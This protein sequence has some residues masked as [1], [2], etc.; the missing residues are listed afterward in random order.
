MTKITIL[1]ARG[2]GDG[3]LFHILSHNLAK[4]GHT[5]TTVHPTLAGLGPWLTQSFSDLNSFDILLLQHDNSLRSFALSQLPNVFCFYGAHVLDKHGPLKSGDFV[6][7]RSRTMVENIESALQQWFGITS[8]DPGLTPPP[9]LLFRRHPRRIVLHNGS[10]DP[11]KNWP[12][13]KFIRLFDRLRK[14][15]Y[16]PVFLPQFPTLADLA[17]FLYESGVLIGND[18]GP[19]HLASALGLPTLII[20]PSAAHMKLWR[21]GWG[22]SHV[23]T[24]LPWKCLEKRWKTFV[25]VKSVGTAFYNNIATNIN[26]Y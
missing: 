2:L 18:S 5:V 17:S 21:P 25:T 15:G 6:C 11:A 3:L 12:R 1:P 20:G 8:R 14:N 4:Q 10:G 26:L 19:G 7:D 24:P 9:G 13:E 22:P 16:D 23:V